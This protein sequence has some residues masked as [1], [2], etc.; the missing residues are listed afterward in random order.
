MKSS[1]LNLFFIGNISISDFKKY[2]DNDVCFYS[3]SMNKLGS[4]IPLNIIENEF[5]FINKSKIKV[6]LSETIQ[7]NLSNIHLAYICDCITLLE[8]IDYDD[9]QSQQ[10]IFDLADPEIKGGYKS[11]EELNGIILELN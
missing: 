4:T 3:Q 8:Q 2:I 7:G 5:I 9:E 6:L 11:I 1:D 10:I